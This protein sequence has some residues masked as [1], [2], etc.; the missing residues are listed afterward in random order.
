M[1]IENSSESLLCRYGIMLFVRRKFKR[2]PTSE[3]AIIR[4]RAVSFP[5]LLPRYTGLFKVI[6]GVQMPSGNSAPNPGNNHNLA[7]P[8]EGGVYSFKRQRVCVSRN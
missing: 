1:P 6:V 8:F 2:M 4:R 3:T 7:I 5:C